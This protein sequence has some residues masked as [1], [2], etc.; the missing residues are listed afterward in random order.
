MQLR[1]YPADVAAIWQLDENEDGQSDPVQPTMSLTACYSSP[2][3]P[4][5]PSMRLTAQQTWYFAPFKHGQ[6]LIRQSGEHIRT[7]PDPIA[8]FY[9]FYQIFLELL[10]LSAAEEKI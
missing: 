2:D 7:N 10:H 4:S 9:Q 1:F 5:L 3:L 8:D 6:P